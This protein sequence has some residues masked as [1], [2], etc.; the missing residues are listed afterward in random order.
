[1]ILAYSGDSFLVRRAVRRAFETRGFAMQDVT[2]LAEGMT[3]GEVA[4]LAAQSGLFGSS[5]LLLDFSAAFKGQAGVKARNEVMKVLATIPEDSLVVVMDLEATPAR[6][7]NFKKL[8]E[9]EQLPTPR[10][11]A[12]SH[13]VRL[14][15]ESQGLTFEKSVPDTLAD[16]FGE[17]LP[18]LAAEINKLSVLDEKLTSEQV[19]RIVNRPASRSAFDLIDAIS[20]KK[21]AM[22][23]QTIHSLVAQGEAPNRILGALTWQYNLLARAVAIKESRSR[24]DATVLTQTL[25]VAPFVAKKTLALSQNIDEPALK[26]ILTNLL[27]AD[28]AIKTGKDEQWALESLALQLAAK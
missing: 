9:F 18:S 7:K 28:V 15:L 27:A 16:L 24:V 17:D 14:E 8:G 26:K 10:F 5:A 21:P 11:G 25:K 13:W 2:E 12:L 3:G 22:A 6:Q 4:Q 23:L 1:M 20:A 19:I